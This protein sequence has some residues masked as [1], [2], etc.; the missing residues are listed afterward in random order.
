MV[1][2]TLDGDLKVPETWRPVGKVKKLFIYPVK[3]CKGLMVDSFLT[4]K[5]AAE[6]EGLVDRQ[7]MIVE[8]KNTMLTARKYPNMVLIEVN[9]KDCF[10]TLS[11]P[12]MEDVS[13]KVPEIT[14]VTNMPTDVFGEKCEGVDL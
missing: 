4:G 3:S 8:K 9:V 7:F 12:G 14:D 13:V 5:H 1:K 10:L 2:Y 11:Y 6:S